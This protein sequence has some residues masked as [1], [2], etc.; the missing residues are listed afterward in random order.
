MWTTERPAT[1]I[2]GSFNP[3]VVSAP[4]YRTKVSRQNAEGSVRVTVAEAG[5]LQSFPADYPWHGSRSKQYE[6]VGNAVPPRLA[7]HILASLGLGD[8]DQLQ[9]AA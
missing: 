5:I 1:T 9:T 7:A 8:L 2:V 6:Q 4:G 3:D